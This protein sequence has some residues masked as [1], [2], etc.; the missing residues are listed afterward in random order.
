MSLRKRNNSQEN[1]AHN[2][3]WS[4]AEKGKGK[5]HKVSLIKPS[6]KKICSKA[7][8]R[9]LNRH[10]WIAAHRR[11][12]PRDAGPPWLQ[13]SIKINYPGKF[14]AHRS[15]W[16]RSTSH[17]HGK[18]G[19]LVRDSTKSN[20]RLGEFENHAGITSKRQAD[21]GR[22]VGQSKEERIVEPTSRASTE[23]FNYEG[24]QAMLWPA[25]KMRK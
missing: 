7:W 22:S 3:P 19:A 6:R 11:D 24:G 23:K 5:A 18:E 14:T 21:A 8:A 1:Y 20:S 10:R 25:G 15:F 12:K 2:P 13:T 9:I 17:T 4:R 16:R